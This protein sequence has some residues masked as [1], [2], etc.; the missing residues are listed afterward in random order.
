MA[1]MSEKVLPFS[2][3][4]VPRD[5]VLERYRGNLG[6]IYERPARR[7]WTVLPVLECI[8]GAMWDRRAL[9]VVSALKP[10]YIRTAAGDGEVKTD[11]RD[12][13]VTV[14]LRRD[15][16]IDRIHQEVAVDFHSDFENGADLAG[17]IDKMAGRR[18]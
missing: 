17:Y 9:D 4:M 2:S 6:A 11:F 1:D 18:W 10:S 8:W 3:A 16:R 13:R 14:F 5:E 15:G 7:G 12:G